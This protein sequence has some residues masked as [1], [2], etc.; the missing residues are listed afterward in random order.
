MESHLFLLVR[1]DYS[2]I[3]YVH[4]V[5]ALRVSQVSGTTI[6][7]RRALVSTSGRTIVQ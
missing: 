2:L 5:A 3:A 7:D 6:F 1:I 4:Y